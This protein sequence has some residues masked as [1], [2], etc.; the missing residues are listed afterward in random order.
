MT[1]HR[2]TEMTDTGQRR[3]LKKGM[4]DEKVIRP[5]CALQ[6]NKGCVGWTFMIKFWLIPS[7]V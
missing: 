4:T 2:A 7:H 6:Y 5:K 3:N 1:E